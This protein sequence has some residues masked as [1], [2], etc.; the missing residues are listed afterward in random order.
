MPN[1]IPAK[2]IEKSQNW[3]VSDDTEAIA[4]TDL[5]SNMSPSDNEVLTWDGNAGEW[6]PEQVLTSFILDL[7]N[8]DNN[9]TTNLA[10]IATENDQNNVVSVPSPDKALFD[11][12]ANWPQADDTLAIAGRAVSATAPG[13]GDVLT[14]DSNNSEWVPESGSVSIEDDGTTVV[15]DASILNFTS[16]EFNISAPSS[17]VADIELE[18]SGIANSKL[19]NNS[20][21][22]AGNNVALG[23]ST[24]I[25]H[26]D[27]SNVDADTDPHTEYVLA[28]ATRDF[29]S[30]PSVSGGAG[31]IN[32]PLNLATK[33]YVDAV[34]QALDIKDSVRVASTSD[35]DLTSNTDPNPI[36]GVT[37][38][39]GDRILLKDQSTA[40]E[41]G[42]YEATTAT[43]PSTWSRTADADEDNEVTSGLFV[44][45]EEGNNS[46]NKGYVLTTND[47]ISVGSDDLTFTQFSGAGQI[48]AG[49][50][51]TKSGDTL[52]VDQNAF[53]S[54]TGNAGAVQYSD[55]NGGFLGNTGYLYIDNS[56]GSV[57][58]GTTSP[59]EDFSV[60]GNLGVKSGYLWVKND[61]NAYVTG[62]MH[63]GGSS[64]P[65]GSLDV[66][67]GNVNIT[68]GYIW[69]KNSNNAFLTG[70]THI[71]GSTTPSNALEI[72]GN[73]TSSGWGG[74]NDKLS[75]NAPSPYGPNAVGTE[76]LQIDGSVG[77]DSY[78]FYHSDS[79][80]NIRPSG[81]QGD[82]LIHQNFGS[83]FSV[84]EVRTRDVDV[85]DTSI[86]SEATLALT[87]TDS[88]ENDVELLD[89]YNNGYHNSN[90]VRHGLRVQK[91]GGGKLRD[92]D[93]EWDDGNNQYLGYSIKPPTDLT[94]GDGAKIHFNVPVGIETASPS[95]KLGVNGDINA[96][97]ELRSG[98]NVV[99]PDS[100]SDA[101]HSKYT[102]SEARG[103]IETG[104]VDNVAFSNQS[105]SSIGNRDL[106]WDDSQGGGGVDGGLITQDTS[107]NNAWVM[108][109]SQGAYDIQK[110]GTDG[111]G[112]I[113]FKTQN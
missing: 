108:H 69:V 20:V 76:E 56:D 90:S 52:N 96:Q 18:S 98:G 16:S 6:K 113:N 104:P 55:G 5:A 89:L 4:G 86:D 2:Y 24:T 54:A 40:S 68:N 82:L 75:V 105:H 47:P 70:K 49:N 107:G 48:I 59:I 19:A 102:D 63:V 12:A 97:G 109:S 42:L 32:D 77:A 44:F 92:F 95:Y 99:S 15:G 73:F 103:A 72:S 1:Q 14:W 43:D 41:N 64:V 31:N 65:T 78:N 23:A 79:S 81:G 51:L 53:T 28:D 37:L 8:D 66:T 74:V 58:V 110:D 60:D 26:D 9:E 94:N 87:R 39:D 101:H 71:G 45:I 84:S 10:E 25:D 38:S 21:T 50:G 30:I 57:G 13:S 112:I 62:D 11:M 61:N 36:D 46:N 33:Q 100:D 111:T 91:R 67:G 88:G 85:T 7:G 35:I 22:V 80:W 29:T 3:P 106:A 17:D 93:F 34:E 27:L 83:N